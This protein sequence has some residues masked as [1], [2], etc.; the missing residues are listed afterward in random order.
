MNS[1]RFLSLVVFLGGFFVSVVSFA[2]TPE[3]N[4][5]NKKELVAQCSAFVTNKT[6]QDFGG[7]KLRIVDAVWN[8]Q[9]NSIQ[10][11]LSY[12][13]PEHCLVTG[14]VNERVSKVDGASYSIDFEIR[15]PANWNQRF[16]FQANGGN[17]GAVIPALGSSLNHPVPALAKNFAVIS[18]N[19]GHQNPQ[20]SLISGANFGHDPEARLDYGYKANQELT[21]VA[22]K[23]IEYFYQQKPQYSYFMGCSNGGRHAMVAASRLANEYDGFI[24]GNP[25]FNLP[26]AAIQHAWDVQVLSK[27]N[28]DISKSLTVEEMTFVADK[29]LE[30]CDDL[31]GISDGLVNDI[32]A[33]QDHFELEKLSCSKKTASSAEKNTSKMSCLESTKIRAL[34]KIFSGPTNSQGEVLYSDWVFDAGIHG[35]DWRRWKVQGPIANLPFIAALGSSSLAKIFMTPPREIKPSPA[36]LLEFLRGFDFDKDARAINTTNDIFTESAMDFMTPPDVSNLLSLSSNGSKLLVTHGAS[37]GVFSVKDTMD[38]YQ[39]LNKN[40]NG[41][42]NSFARLFVV[43]GMNHCGGGPTTDQ[44]DA[45]SVMV[46]WAEKGKA[47]NEMTATVIPKNSELPASWS[48]NRSRKMCPFPLVARYKQGDVE[49]ADSFLCAE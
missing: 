33:C 38:W 27:V 18:S 2:A 31:D 25:G 49:A 12:S 41:K 24:A 42:A 4:L 19:A 37:D 20:T 23:I 26:K 5:L 15:L 10:K 16:L 11:S 36:S 17:D 34:N 1:L 3:K 32:V 8:A 39:A 47:P 43:P 40:H 6:T 22:K 46:E 44:F 35:A 29:V 28:S 14:K 45:L 21:P 9:N 13:L 30:S 48:K 7:N